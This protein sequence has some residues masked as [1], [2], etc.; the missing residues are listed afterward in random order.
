MERITGEYIL[1]S[2]KYDPF[3]AFVPY[4]LPPNPPLFLDDEICDLM[5]KANRALGRLDG[6][7]TLLPG[8]YQFTYFYIR[9]EAVLSSQI[10]GTQSS[11]QELL[12]FETEVGLTQEPS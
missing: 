10:E 12:L 2:E 4:P 6:V 1:C 3:K 9:K 8:T 5:E 11:L 7:T